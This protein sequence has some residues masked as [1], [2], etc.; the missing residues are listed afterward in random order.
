MEPNWYWPAIAII[1]SQSRTIHV[2][3]PSINGFRSSYKSTI[4]AISRINH[5][6]PVVT[7]A[8]CLQPDGENDNGWDQGLLFLNPSQVW[9]QSPGYVT[10]MLAGKFQSNLVYWQVQSPG[11]VL[12]VTA[13]RSLDPKILVLEVVNPSGQ[14]VESAITL[15]G[16]RTSSSVS[17]AE[18]LAGP[19]D[20]INTAQEPG[21]LVPTKSWWESKFNNG[22]TQYTFKPYSYTI[23]SFR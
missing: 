20:S 17:E 9:L 15:N 18:E 16:F 2:L 4:N 22:S 12:D 6:L 7:S 14:P 3:R 19:L 21:N 5:A 8:N 1:L 10:Q 13:K 11:G 23:L